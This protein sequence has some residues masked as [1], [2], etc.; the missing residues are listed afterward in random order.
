MKKTNFLA[1]VLSLA[2]ALGALTSCN[3]GSS[4]DY[5]TRQVLS[6]FINVTNDY[7]TTGDVVANTGVGYV[8]ELNMTK[9]V[10]NITIEGVKLPNGT[11]FG[12]L[13]LVNV[14]FTIKDG[15]WIEIN[16]S[17]V[18]PVTSAGLQ[19]PTMSSFVFRICDRM[20]ASDL[21]YPLFDIR[22]TMEGY[23]LVSV[24]PSVI[25]S[26]NTVVSAPGQATYSPDDEE[27]PPLYGITFDVTNKKANL[28]IQGAKFASA[29]PALNMSFQDIPF[30]FLSNGTA[31]LKS[32]YLEPVLV[33][34]SNSTTP[35]PNYPITNLTCTTD[36]MNNMS[37]QFTCTIK[38][39]N[40]ETSIPYSVSV[41]CKTPTSN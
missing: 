36:D 25:N 27:V 18:V 8:I 16:Q 24:P 6:N 29:M 30:E 28:T 9:A 12:Q 4:S 19:A 7:T 5:I 21:Y 31:V 32:D 23:N 17:M 20:L 3:T 38:S 11:T 10:A 40:D 2:A 13:L 33:T 15:G 39:A 14:P 26:G 22:Y 1:L 37:L 35:M 41:S 34:G